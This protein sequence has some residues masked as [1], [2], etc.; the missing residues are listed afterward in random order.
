MSVWTSTMNIPST[1][2]SEDKTRR[3]P[4][5][6]ILATAALLLSAISFI[7]V[8]AIPQP[9]QAF[10]QTVDQSISQNAENSVKDSLVI[11][12]T[13]SIEQNAAN[14]GVAVGNEDDDGDDEGTSVTQSITQNAE[15]EVE[16]SNVGSNTQ[17][18]VQNALN[19][20][21]A[22]DGEDDD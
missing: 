12:N 3:R 20:G 2:N 15:N 9:Q 14:I 6:Y 4:R 17:D 13:Q 10:A 22:A 18:I 1:G 21:I 5:L 7:G 8:G 19:F 11:E 16:G